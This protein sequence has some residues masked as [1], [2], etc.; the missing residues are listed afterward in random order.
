MCN[1]AYQ[2]F[3]N[4]AAIAKWLLKFKHSSISLLVAGVPLH[5]DSALWNVIVYLSKDSF[6]IR[7][8]TSWHQNVDKGDLL[9]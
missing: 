9:D 8:S 7:L 3:N 1:I 5:Y 2:P 6:I 4:V